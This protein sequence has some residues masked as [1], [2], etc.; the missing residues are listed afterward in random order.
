VDAANPGSSFVAEA[1]SVGGWIKGAIAGLLIK[2]GGGKPDE[3]RDP[4]L[5]HD[6]R[7]PKVETPEKMKD[8]K[9]QGQE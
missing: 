7:R 9:E 3:R 4:L 6:Q 8:E 1:R 2:L 5:E